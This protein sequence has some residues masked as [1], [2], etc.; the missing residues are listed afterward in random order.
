MTGTKYNAIK[1]ILRIIFSLAFIIA[2]I[3]WPA[4]TFKWPEGWIFLGAYILFVLWIF[5]WL[6]KNNPELL[7]ERMNSIKR[8]DAKPWDKLIIIAFVGL[9]IGMLILA[10]LDAVRFQWS[11]APLFIQVLGFSGLVLA[12]TLAFWAMRENSF[13]SG[14]VRIQSERGHTVC[15]S[16]PYKYIRHPLYGADI[17]ILFCIPLFLGSLYALIPA[18]LAALLFILRTYLEDK[19]LLNELPG[20]REYTEQVRY[21]LIPG[22][23]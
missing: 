5:L 19:T 3:F 17:I 22:V 23:W 1:L 4:G 18:F 20:Y 10:G 16:G 6:K 14:I 13:L 11:Q 8:K 2:I 21:R 7:K 12:A 9:M 15:T